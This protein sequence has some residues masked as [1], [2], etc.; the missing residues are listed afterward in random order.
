[1]E[2][3]RERQRI[4]ARAVMVDRDIYLITDKEDPGAKITKLTELSNSGLELYIM[5]R[6]IYLETLKREL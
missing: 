3:S 5:M 1:M 4:I 6:E 2:K